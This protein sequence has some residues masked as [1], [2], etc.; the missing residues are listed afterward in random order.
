MI[1]DNVD[2]NNDN[3]NKTYQLTDSND[4]QHI[5]I[6]TCIGNKTVRKVMK[7]IKRMMITTI[8]L[9]KRINKLTVIFLVTIKLL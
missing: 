9:I 8:M 2:N 4:A 6:Y 3:V 7:F 5:Y 1:K